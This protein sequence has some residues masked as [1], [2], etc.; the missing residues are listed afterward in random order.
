MCPQEMSEIYN[1]QACF[2]EKPLHDNLIH[3]RRRSQHTTA[4]VWNIG[5]FEQA[6]N[7]AVFTISAMQNRYDT[8]KLITTIRL[9]VPGEPS[10]PRFSRIAN[11]GDVLSSTL[12]D[13]ARQQVRCLARREPLALFGDGNRH[14]L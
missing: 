3:S 6:L 8:I 2:A 7:R 12:H 10:Q 1:R 11:N 13:G 5:H 9:T 4:D 14:D